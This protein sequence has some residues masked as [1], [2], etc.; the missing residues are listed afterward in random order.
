ML[1]NIRL[2]TQLGLIFTLILLLT[3][4]TAVLGW[5]GQQ[6]AVDRTAKIVNIENIAKM[7]YH[8]RL[9]EKNFVIRNSEVAIK[10]LQQSLQNLMSQSEQLKSTFKAESNRKQ[11]DNIIAAAKE[12]EK[13]FLAYAAIVEQKENAAQIMSKSSE[14]VLQKSIDIDNTQRLLLAQSLDEIE[15]AT[16]LKIEGES[17]LDKL[18]RLFMDARNLQTALRYQYNARQVISVES[19]NEQFFNTLEKARAHLKDNRSLDQLDAVHHSYQTYQTL[20]KEYLNQKNT[21]P[22]QNEQPQHDEEALE[23]IDLTVSEVLRNLQTLRSEQFAEL[24]ETISSSNHLADSRLESLH[25]ANQIMYYYLIARQQESLYF[26]DGF[27]SHLEQIASLLGKTLVIADNLIATLKEQSNINR[28]KGLIDASKAYLAELDKYAAL[29][30]QQKMLDDQMIESARQVMKTTQ[31]ILNDQESKIVS[32]MKMT[33][34]KILISAVVAALISLWAAIWITRLITNGLRENIALMEKIA[35]GDLRQQVEVKKKDELGQL[36]NALNEMQIHLY[37]VVNQV[38]QTTDQLFNIAGNITSTAKSLSDSASQQA[39]GVEEVSAAI[40]EMTASIEQNA[41]NSRHTNKI[42][43]ESAQRADEG[44]KAVDDTVNAM[45]QIANKVRIVEEVAY[46]TNLLALNAAIE[47]ARAGEHGSGFAVVA[48]E[49]RTLAEHT[50]IAAREILQLVTN[51]LQVAEKAGK[52]LKDIVPIAKNTAQL[53]E[54]ITYSSDE[55]SAGVQQIN[56]TMSNLDS[57]TQ[58]TAAASEMLAATAEIM[59]DEAN[60]LQQLMQFFKL[61]DDNGRPSPD[62]HSIN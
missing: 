25:D 37:A 4:G 35:N 43:T 62:A 17:Y 19:L 8:A 29:N 47:A 6:Q 26:K 49:V 15:N 33:N 55:Q 22:P 12:Y 60:K 30:Q 1:K 42:A 28:A 14:E 45:Q 10:N 31:D 39:A 9:Q 5:L 46:K 38:R 53:V 34:Q 20:Y 57:V 44:G 56:S 18:M 48:E 36:R 54:G 21:L 23:E 41:D 52:L 24:K 51:G 61:Q 7:L 13:H 16:V 27:E 59:N 3:S 2:S 50:Q 58:H 40:E 11:M 32:E